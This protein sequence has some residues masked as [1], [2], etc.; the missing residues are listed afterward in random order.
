M[1]R[2]AFLGLLTALALTGA[3]CG[4]Y[5]TPGFTPA[6]PSQVMFLKPQEGALLFVNVPYLIRFQGASFT[7][8]QQFEVK[9]SDGETWYVNP[10]STGSGGAD[11]GTVFY[12][13]VTWIP[14]LPGD[15]TLKVR[16]LNAGDQYSTWTEVHV[17]V[18]EA[19]PSPTPTPATLRISSVMNANCRA[20]PGTVH[21]ETGFVQKG[22]T[23]EVVGRNEEGTW[24]KVVNPNGDGF[25]WVSIIA[26]EIL[27][28]PQQL[29]VAS[30]PTAPASSGPEGSSGQEG[31][32]GNEEA[33]PTGCTVTS[34]LNNQTRCVSPC[35]RG[36]VPGE[37]CTP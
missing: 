32:G 20:G 36:A 33:Q 23:V 21:N 14:D 30:A 37:T 1:N 12:G 6:P 8:I 3:S 29:P 2:I 16:A 31:Q 26:F 24:L 18:V 27:S 7:G 10:T 19:R 9:I 13:E 11:Y 17:L 15:Y 4:N 22:D 35:P 28:D 34:P 5:P 25:C